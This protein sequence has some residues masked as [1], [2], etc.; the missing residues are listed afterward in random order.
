MEV[1][2]CIV[3]CLLH[4]NGSVKVLYYTRIVTKSHICLPGDL[5]CENL[6]I[7]V[8]EVAKKLGFFHVAISVGTWSMTD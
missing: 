7:H 2:Y 5:S 1:F 4:V 6:N 3:I 8:P